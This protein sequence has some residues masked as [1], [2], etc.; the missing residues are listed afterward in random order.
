MRV[1]V[2]GAN[3]QLGSDLVEV[4]RRTD[5][6]VVALDHEN[7]RVEDADSVRDVLTSARPW[8]VL[9]T[10]AYHNLPECEA[11]PERSF[12]VNSVGALNLARVCAELDIVNV[13]LSTD[14]VF[15]GAPDAG[16]NRPP[17][18]E[19]DLPRPLNVYGAS[20]LAGES[21]TLGHGEKA[22]VVRVSGLYGQAPCRAKG[23]SFVDKMIRFASERDEVRVVDDEILSPTPTLE[24]A[25]RL[26]AVLESA[27]FGLYHLV[28]AGSCSWYEL[29]REVFDH[30]G[31]K[32][33][34][35]RAKVSDFPSP[36][37]RPTYSAL[38]CE[39]YDRLG[40]EPMPDWR[41]AVR[42]FLVECRS[43]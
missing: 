43:G 14:Y 6:E 2:I 38:A 42:R 8:A 11:D 25:R 33:P 15:D 17:Y 28:S 13:Y 37:R 30:L 35:H 22:Y 21:L 40:L 7:V 12:R 27:P 1:A 41:T 19:G 31:I 9:N 24:I 5:H 26:P 16:G 36:V 18:T 10:A 32:T 4:L 20:K 23:E 29:A 39:A 34:L 3:G